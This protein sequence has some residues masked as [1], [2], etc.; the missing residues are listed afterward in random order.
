M[1][2]ESFIISGKFSAVISSYISSASL[3]LLKQ[4]F[5]LNIF[6]HLYVFD[7]LCWFSLYFYLFLVFSSLSPYGLLRS[8]L[9]FFVLINLFLL[10]VNN[11]LF[12]QS[13]EVF[14]ILVITIFISRTSVL[15]FFKFAQ[16]LFNLQKCIFIL[17]YS[18][19]YNSKIC[20]LYIGFYFLSLMVQLI[21]LYLITFF[22]I[23]C[24]YALEFYL[25]KCVNAW[26]EGRYSF[27][28]PWSPLN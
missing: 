1:I 26:F 23:H 9:Q 13:I 15:C 28:M 8:S 14:F 11:L 22:I 17:L 3:S 19:S 25:W 2:V 18:M 27:Q 24:P 5:Q 10:D 16:I 4:K 20:S 6:T 21:S 12:N 7:L